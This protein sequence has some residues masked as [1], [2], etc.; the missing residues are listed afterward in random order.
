MTQPDIQDEAAAGQREYAFAKAYTEARARRGHGR[1]YLAGLG[2]LGA[3]VLPILYAAVT[4]WLS[5]GAAPAWM[6]ATA[7]LGEAFT[8]PFPKLG[9]VA[10][11]IFGSDPD[12]ASKFLSIAGVDLLCI[13]GAC[14]CVFSFL[15]RPRLRPTADGMQI[16]FLN[17]LAKG[18]RLGKKRHAVR[19]GGEAG[20]LASAML[21][22]ALILWGL[23]ALFLQPMQKGTF[24]ADVRV[25]CAVNTAPLELEDTGEPITP[26]CLETQAWEIAW[27]ASFSAVVVPIALLIALN[28]AIY[29]F[30]LL[31]G[32]PTRD[33]RAGH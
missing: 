16:S 33:D 4:P 13:V 2:W 27:G 26:N 30:W 18:F 23:H 28:Y 9:I 21:V 14:L 17:D 29:P 20:G 5:A 8:I 32:R 31:S 7:Y 25:D 22:V 15:P 10:Q 11:Q 3:I 12:G 1:R 6:R 19:V 24:F